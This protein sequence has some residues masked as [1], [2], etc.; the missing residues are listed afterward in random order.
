MTEVDLQRLKEKLLR[1]RQEIFTSLRD[2]EA[3]WEVLGERDIEP[4]DAAQK[5][6]LTSLFDQMDTREKD[7]IEEIDLAL[8]KMES[9]SY[10]TCEE[11]HKPISLQR[12]ESLPATRFCIKCAGKQEEIH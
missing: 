11:C 9:A 10:G 3:E 8:T 7:R 12:L 2:L 5:A 6:A 4:E 1:Q